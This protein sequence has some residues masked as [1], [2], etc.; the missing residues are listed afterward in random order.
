MKTITLFRR[1]DVYCRIGASLPVGLRHAS[2][3]HF[4]VE[5]TTTVQPAL[6]RLR[7]HSSF[8]RVRAFRQRPKFDRGTRRRPPSEGTYYIVARPNGGK[9]QALVETLEDIANGTHRAQWFALFHEGSPPTDFMTI[10]GIRR[11][12]FRL[13]PVG[14]WGRSEGC[15]T[16][17]H[18]SQFD[19]LRKW[20]TA[21]PPENIPGTQIPS[22]GKVIVR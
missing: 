14:Y 18:P 22:Y 10:N 13:H 19:T 16:L 6:P 8:F 12:R 9:H 1:T 20:L 21:H 5:P 2:N 4:Y 3:L 11:G 15:I 7:R 17:P